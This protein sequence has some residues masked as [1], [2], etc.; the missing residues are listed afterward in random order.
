M[1]SS[2]A[3]ATLAALATAS[4]QAQESGQVAFV[5]CP[6][7]QDT[8]SVPCWLVEY[9]GETLYMGIQTDVSAEFNPPSLGHQVLVEGT[10]T[11]RE[12]CGA[13]V[14]DPIR[15]SIMP[16]LSPECDEMRPVR[17][18]VDLGFEPPRPPGP[19][20][21]RLAFDYIPETPSWS[22][23]FEQMSF[24]VPYPYE[25]MIGFRSVFT[26]QPAFEYALGIEASRIEVVGY[27]SA[28]RLSDG[29]LLIEREGIA[30]ER[31]EEVARMLRGAGLENAEFA[32]SA[33]DEAIEG[34]PDVR[35][36]EI[37]IVP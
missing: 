11:D 17:A 22:P 13:R 3:V 23:P 36:V 32:V 24:T 33:H 21:G 20:L 34:G 7:V 19:S 31:A 9:Q 25:G 28:T 1:R 14:I 35:R 18:D 10:I 15:I 37:T 2:I 29:T 5:S 6:I 4:A 26:M 8:P 12:I 30:M 16:E 27:R